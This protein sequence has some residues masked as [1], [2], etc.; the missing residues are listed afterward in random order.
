MSLHMAHL[1]KQGQRLPSAAVRLWSCCVVPA[2]TLILIVQLPL[3]SAVHTET[4][5]SPCFPVKRMLGSTVAGKDLREPSSKALVIETESHYKPYNP[6]ASASLVL[7]FRHTPPHTAGSYISLIW[8]FSLPV[9]LS[10]HLSPFYF[11]ISVSS[12]VLVELLAPTREGRICR[13]MG[14]LAL[15]VPW[16]EE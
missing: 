7:G 4:V 3:Q 9:T 10:F 1:A 6:P 13:N 16:G 12:R 15:A 14:I 8:S 2:A 5:L 11:L